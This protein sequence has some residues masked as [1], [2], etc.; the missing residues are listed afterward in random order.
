MFTEA[1]IET[2][3]SIHTD[4]R[5]NVARLENVITAKGTS[6]ARSQAMIRN[7]VTANAA[8]LALAC[9]E[10]G[11]GPEEARQLLTLPTVLGNGK[12]ETPSVADLVADLDA[13][14]D[15]FRA[16]K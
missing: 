15:P 13:G 4:A 8:A 16:D 14:I 6:T 7:V 9:A 5:A 2:L 1:Q 3:T 11:I 10:V 12:V